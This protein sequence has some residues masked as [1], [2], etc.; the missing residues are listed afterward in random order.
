MP[1][2]APAPNRLYAL[3][4]PRIERNLLLSATAGS[5]TSPWP[6]AAWQSGLILVSAILLGLVVNH[7]RPD[8]LP[9]IGHWA[10]AEQVK[11]S[12]LP[13]T[14]IIS[15]DDAQV[16]FF[17]Q[18]A[19]FIDA[20]SEALYREGHIEGAVNLPWDDYDRRVNDVM[21]AVPK[22]AF[23]ITYCDGEGCSLSKELAI[24]LTAVG[25]QNVHI[26]VNGWTLW[27]EAR[28]PTGVSGG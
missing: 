26:L 28:L 9:L 23:V 17:A 10:P 25:Y 24:A 18:Q 11:S 7:L 13:D 1:L 21:Q 20:R 19:V 4:P 14:T 5:K 8:G 2:S 12:G 16:L 27:L 6:R 3:T 15:L 22:N